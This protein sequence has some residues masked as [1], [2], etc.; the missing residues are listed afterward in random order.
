LATALVGSTVS[1]VATVAAVGVT[2]TPAAAVS[3]DV[4]ISQVYGAG[5]NSGAPLTNDYVELFNRGSATVSLNGWSVQYASAAGTGTFAATPLTGSIAAGQY[6]LVQLGGGTNGVA[7]PAPDATG[8]TLMGATAGKVI[9]ANVATGIPCNGGSDPCDP[10]ELASIV[11]LVGYGTTANFFE[12]TGPTPAPSTTTAVWRANNGCLDTDQNSLDFATAAPAP[13]NTASP[14]ASCSVVVG[15]SITTEPESQTIASG[16]TATLNVVA[17]G[18]APLSYQWYQGTAPDTSSPVGTDSSSFTTPPLTADTSYWVRVSNSGGSDDSA[19]AVISISTAAVCSAADTLIGAVQGSGSATPIPGPVT[20][21]GTVVGDFEGGTSPQLRGFYLQDGGDGNPATSDG[22]FVFSGTNVDLVSLGQEVQVSGTAAEFQDQTQISGTLTV[23]SCGTTGTVTPVDV[24]LP[25]ASA[26]AL[27]AFEGMLVRFPETLYVTEHFQLGRFGQVVVSSSDRLDQPTQVVAPGA[28]AIARQELNNRSR[29]IVD[30]ASQAQNPDPIVFARG[31]QPLSASNTLRGGDTLTGATGVMTYT[32]AGNAASGNAYRLRPINALGGSATFVAANPRPSAPPA[33]GGSVQVASFNLLNYFN[34]FGATA[35][36]FGVGGGVTECRGANNTTEFE[37]QAAKTVAAITALDADVLG[38]ME[39]E[40]DGYG[41]GSAIQDLVG[42]LNAATAP[43][44]WAFVDADSETGIT[45]AGGDD[46]I[47]V[48]ILYKPGVVTPVDGATFAD[49]TADVWD[50]QPVAQTFEDTAGGRFSVVV[51]H[52]KS[53]G[54]CPTTDP[55]VDPDAD[56]GDGQSCWNARRVLQAETLLSFISSDIVPAA[57][58]PDVVVLGDLNSYAREDPISTL[59][60]GGFT[61]LGP[62]YDPDGYSYVFDGQWGSLDHVMANASLVGQVTDAGEYHINADEPSVLDYNTEFKSAGQVASLFAP[63][64]FRTSDHDPIVV[65][66]DLDTPAGVTGTPPA[67]TVG[68]PYSYAFT[69]TGTPPVTF[70]VTDGAVPPG[71]T[72][73]ST[74]VLAGTPTAAGTFSFEVTA[75]NSIGSSSASFDVTIGEASTATTLSSSLNPSVLGWPVRVTATV[76][77]ANP[78]GT[79]QFAVDGV[80]VGAPV[81]VS[82]GSASRNLTS[83]SAG[84][85]SIVATYSGDANNTGSVSAPFTQVVTYRLTVLKPSSGL[86]VNAGSS[87]PVQF[88][89]TDIQGRRIS[90][91]EAASLVASSSCRATVSVTGAQSFG[92]TCARY[93]ARHNFFEVVWK[94]ARTPK[95]LVALT[96]RVTYPGT[97]VETTRTVNLRLV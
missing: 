69:A 72:L 66:L 23:E 94:T 92:P 55:L 33:V 59:E 97:T 34:T 63:D 51:N 67:G 93:D 84:A 96:V 89:L 91:A 30:D 22:I 43:G 14:T 16:A 46:A 19:T 75:S 52:F 2:S 1:V 27:E 88:I 5:G 73:S 21:Q 65:G 87:V 45:N 58:D 82:G 61:N 6:Y 24:D 71:L 76:T 81:V 44:T 48:A 62:A 18:T 20:V 29:V 90:D 64:E 95:G 78:T 9:V 86:R 3:P 83:L 39:L 74:G 31:G 7:L 40:N 11:D 38:V 68:T 57:D 35:C 36:T 15:P 25:V 26:T 49:T 37:R 28:P 85:H 41:P 17:T 10:A 50:R 42:R 32:W 53:K 79:V 70:A 8:G 60:T 77:G 80:N 54:S 12:G 56:Q 13:R 4:V 47:K